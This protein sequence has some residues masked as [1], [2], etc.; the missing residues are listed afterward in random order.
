MCNCEKIAALLRLKAQYEWEIEKAGI[1][2]DLGYRY[3]QNNADDRQKRLMKLNKLLASLTP[4][5]GDCEYKQKQR[6][7]ARLAAQETADSL[8]G[9]DLMKDVDARI[10]AL[11]GFESE[12]KEL[13]DNV[14]EINKIV[15]DPLK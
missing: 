12:L 3:A 11:N 14:D 10:Q 2:V 7:Q 4:C 8:K 6:E 1:E 15:Y 5:E 9:T 13:K